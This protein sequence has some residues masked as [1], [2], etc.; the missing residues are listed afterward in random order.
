[1]Q[2]K[3]LIIIPCYN[4]VNRIDIDSFN[5]FAKED[6]QFDCCFVN[7]GS[8]DDTLTAISK[9]DSNKNVYILDLKTNIGKA[10]A[11]RF[12]VKE[13]KDKNY[14]YIGYLDAD[15][16]TSLEEFK[17]LFNS[18]TKDSHFV[19]GS[20]LKKMGSNIKRSK[21]R[22]FFGR[23][24]ATFVDS[25]VLKLGIYDTQCGAKIIKSDLAYSIFEKPFKTKWLFDIELIVR[26]KKQYGK[27]YC[28]KHIEEIPLKE[29]L[30]TEDTRISFSDFLKTPFALLKLYRYY[31]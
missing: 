11:I 12:A 8:N 13:F 24:V 29:W 21:T 19:I 6:N 28:I 31:R 30:D 16:S 27:E 3:V 26:T 4:E 5:S 10:E 25:M 1:M 9:L 17:R 15:L 22:H 20:R 7:D 14:S 2:E 18:K 23:I